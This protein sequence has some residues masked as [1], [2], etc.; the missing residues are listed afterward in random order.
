M[1]LRPGD[2]FLFGGKPIPII[3]FFG[4]GPPPTKRWDMTDIVTGDSVGG[5]VPLPWAG[6]LE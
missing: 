2:A 1:L 4:F 6:L 5:R 3:E